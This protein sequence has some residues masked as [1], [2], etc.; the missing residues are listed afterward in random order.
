MTRTGKIAHLPHEIREQLNCRIQNGEQGKA[1]LKWLNALPLVRSV[2]KLHFDGRPLA[3]SNLTEWK[4][5]GYRDWQVR[6]DALAIVGKLNDEHAFGGNALKDAFNNKP[7][8]W[9]SIHYTPAAHALVASEL[10]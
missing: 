10:D 5:G 1:I 9:I 8:Q 4:N 3:P 2:L 6:Q 7:A